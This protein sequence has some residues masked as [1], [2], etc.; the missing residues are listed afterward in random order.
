MCVVKQL[1]EELG[2]SE[3]Y[4]TVFVDGKKVNL[5]SHVDEKALLLV[6]HV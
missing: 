4:L 5:D 3:Y 2:L 6:Y 1:F